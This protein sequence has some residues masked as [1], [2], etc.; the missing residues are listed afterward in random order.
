MHTFDCTG[1]CTCFAKLISRLRTERCCAMV[2]EDS[3]AEASYQLASMLSS[4]VQR[5]ALPRNWGQGEVALL[6]ENPTLQVNQLGTNSL[7]SFVDKTIVPLFKAHGLAKLQQHLC[8]SPL[9]KFRTDQGAVVWRSDQQLQ[10]FPHTLLMHDETMILQLYLAPG[11]AMLC[12]SDC[13]E[14]D[15]LT[16]AHLLSTLEPIESGILPVGSTT[17]HNASLVQ[18]GAAQARLVLLIPVHKDKSEHDGYPDLR[19]RFNMVTRCIMR[20]QADP[21]ICLPT[22]FDWQALGFDASSSWESP[23][24]KLINCIDKQCF[25]GRIS[26]TL[27]QRHH[28]LLYWNNTQLPRV[29]FGL[30]DDSLPPAVERI[31]KAPCHVE[32]WNGAVW[33][34]QCPYLQPLIDWIQPRLD[35]RKHN[36]YVLVSQEQ[37]DSIAQAVN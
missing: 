33:L 29:E 5:H 1:D 28:W 2:P 24:R 10:E 19:E 26:I 31:V 13:M 25:S 4:D 16:P 30:L 37:W 22:L 18:S 34:P 17:L 21:D 36:R 23:M 14:S 6:S 3:L 27:V 20:N 7:Q 8:R 12:N 35:V 32:F 15:A 9:V 11:P